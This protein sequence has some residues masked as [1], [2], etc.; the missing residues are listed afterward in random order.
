M[1]AFIFGRAKRAG[2]TFHPTQTCPECGS[3]LLC[4]RDEFH[5]SQIRSVSNEE[6]GASRSSA[7]RVEKLECPNPDCPAQV[8]LGLLHWCSPEVMDIAGGDEKMV[9]LLVQHGLVRDVAELYR[10]KVKE[11]AA[12]PGLTAEAAQKFFDAITASMKRDAWR[13]L[14]GLGIPLVGAAEAQAVAKGF[15]TVD[16]VFAAGVP[17][18]MKDAG[19]SEAVAQS[20]V[21]WYS[22]GVNRKLVKRLEKFGLNFKSELHHTRR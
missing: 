19:V 12:L 7:R 4:W 11:L 18:L 8:R 13:L 5:E 10:L 16:A 2:E 9:A 17:R 6:D 22:D 21:R 15:P 3:K 20:L 14:F 1:K